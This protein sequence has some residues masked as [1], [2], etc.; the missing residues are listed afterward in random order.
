MKMAESTTAGLAREARE[1][2]ASRMLQIERTIEGIRNTINEH[3]ATLAEIKANTSP[4]PEL[5]RRLRENENSTSS[6]WTVLK[7]T[8]AVIV[9][10]VGA[11]WIWVRH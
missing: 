1:A 9:V 3:G 6:L 7:V 4:L 8:W 11:A 2:T 10:I 5:R